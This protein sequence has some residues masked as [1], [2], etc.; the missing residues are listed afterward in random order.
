[1]SNQRLISILALA[2][3]AVLL[4]SCSSTHNL[5]TD[6]TNVMGGGFLDDEVVP[7]IHRLTAS[8]NRAPWP[9][10]DAA[11]E[12]WKYRADQLCGKDAH[13]SFETSV[14]DG[15]GAVPTII[16]LPSAS[17]FVLQS[18][19]ASI[20]GYVVCSSTGM[21][22]PQAQRFLLAREEAARQQRI[23]KRKQAL[24]ELGGEHCATSGASTDGE[25][26]YLRGKLLR[27]LGRLAEARHCF[28]AAQAASSDH[29]SVHYRESCEA[30]GL[31]YEVGIGVLKDPAA[32][33]EWYRKAGLKK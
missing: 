12:T 29:R 2:C 6:G 27:D 22:I 3:G 18:Y 26:L 13:Q 20:G 28:F 8:S 10:M 1:M 14:S 21:S 19:N 23:D 11:R 30:L 25:S 32:A 17:M 24:A 15:L 5:K 4:A 16:F 9:S 7:G 33:D 31:M